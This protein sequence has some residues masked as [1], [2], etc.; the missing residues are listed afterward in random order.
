ME[1]CPYCG[2]YL[3]WDYTTGDVICSSCGVVVDRIVV[4][5]GTINLT[6]EESYQDDKRQASRRSMG[7][8]KAGN[9]YRKYMTVAR[10]LLARGS[11]FEINEKNFEEY[12]QGKRG[13]VRLIISSKS[14]EALKYA[15]R[16]AEVKKILREIIPKIPSLNSRTDRARVAAALLIKLLLNKNRVSSTDLRK[17]S[18]T[19]GV[20][21]SHIRRLYNTVMKLKVV[22]RR[23]R[24]MI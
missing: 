4:S 10:H 5:T 17:V 8:V 21:A 2:S 11:D 3:V 24:A 23:A 13:H 22:Q 16:D 7:Y 12:L 9:V 6:H 1:R 19:T 20:S 14:R 18:Q 15:E